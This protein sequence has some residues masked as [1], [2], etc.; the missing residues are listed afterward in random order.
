LNLLFL[1][2][3]PSGA[4]V[5]FHQGLCRLRSFGGILGL[6]PVLGGQEISDELY[7]QPFGIVGVFYGFLWELL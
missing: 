7:L 6:E 5:P 3:S 1:F 4:Y 2:L